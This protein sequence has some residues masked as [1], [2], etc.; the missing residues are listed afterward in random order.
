MFAAFVAFAVAA[1]PLQVEVF[2]ASPEGFLVTSTLV[3]GEKEVVLIDAQFTRADAH[4]LV[5]KVLESKKKLTT[6]L[7]T[8]AHPDH[9]F[10][11]EVVLQAFPKAA[12]VAPPAVLEEL[13]R[14]GAGKLGYWK[15]VYG[16]G[17]TDAVPQPKPFEGKALELEGQKLELLSLPAGESDAAVAVWIPSAKTLVAGDA[18]YRDVHLYLVG[19]DA[20]HRAGWAAN[21]KTLQGLGAKVVVPGHQ[22]PGAMDAKAL[23]QTAAY[24]K[25]YEAAVK[26]G[27]N[28]EAVVKAV[29]AKHGALELPI[30][31]E[32]SAKSAKP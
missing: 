2:T 14:I 5:A 9:L 31:L 20:A 25:D 21:V 16:D 4:R 32:L 19:A 22:R 28:A 12:L 13:G 29:R 24:L 11:A 10:G 18:A 27:A 3:S 26:A 30:I 17:L 8:H 23:E 7:V 15:G 1:A 6:V